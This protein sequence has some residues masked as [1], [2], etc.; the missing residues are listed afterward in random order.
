MKNLSSVVQHKAHSS[1]D[2]VESKRQLRISDSHQVGHVTQCDTQNR[3]QNIEMEGQKTNYKIGKMTLT[4]T[5]TYL[6]IPATPRN[7]YA[8]CCSVPKSNTVPIPT[9]PVLGAPQVLPY[10][11]GT[12][13]PSWCDV[14]FLS[15]KNTERK[16]N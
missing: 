15:E 2:V 8:V 14:C 16:K 12:L 13:I 4:L 3:N 1:H 5:I 10:L 9:L 7:G 11:C 6:C